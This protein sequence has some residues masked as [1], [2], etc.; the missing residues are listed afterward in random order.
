MKF[1]CLFLGYL[2][3][4]LVVDSRAKVYNVNHHS[5]MVVC[6]WG[7]WANYRPKDGKF[8]PEDVDPSL[9]TH[10]IYSFVGLNETTN[11]IKSLDTWM[12]LEENYGLGGF[13]KTTD[14][15]L[16]YPHLKVTLAIG[17]WNDGSKK[18][19]DMARDPLWRKKFVRSAALFVLLHKFDGLDIDWEYPAR[20]GGVPE[21]KDNFILLLADLHRVF[22]RQDLLLTTAIGATAQT[23]DTSY[24]IPMM[25]KYLDY[26]H[27]MCY[28]YH[29]KWDKVTGHNAPLHPRPNE[30]PSDQA[31]NLA[32]TFAYLMEMGAVPEKTVM[33]IPFYGRAYKLVLPIQNVMG[34][35]TKDDAF[36]GPYTREDGFMG[37]N[38]ICEEQMDLDHPWT[39]VWEEHTMAPYMF[40]GN[41]WVSF[42]DE[43]S[44]EHKTKFAYD[45]GLAGVMVWSI[46]TDDF[47]GTCGG[48][49]FPLLRTLNLALVRREMGLDIID[50]DS[51]SLGCGD[52]PGIVL[53][54]LCG[55]LTW[56]LS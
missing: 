55:V 39:Y 1:Y 38:E 17:G 50:K 35:P 33:G 40:R 44:L 21:D 32:Y 56:I 47:R 36:Q 2:T 22:S 23:V 51:G 53:G 54:I 18:Y 6:Y 14:L 46:D 26:V 3:A 11:T 49:K 24:N 25:Y 31:L 15:K 42:D 37:Y 45:Q 20:R 41:R 28:D 29:G 9:C 5:K 52:M 4:I 19:S 7:T 30:S 16:R 43:K 34:S 27:V 8:T 48:L 13:K 10:L 12:D